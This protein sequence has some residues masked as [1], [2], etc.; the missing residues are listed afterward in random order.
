M[1]GVLA[2][3][4]H[5]M[6]KCHIYLEEEDNESINAFVN[7]LTYLSFCFTDRFLVCIYQLLARMTGAMVF[8]FSESLQSAQALGNISS[9]TGGIAV[10]RRGLVSSG[11]ERHIFASL[12]IGL[13]R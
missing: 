9:K 12:P 5:V 7:S 1:L 8:Y 10:L 13:S 2:D 6:C 4:V 3:F 11:A